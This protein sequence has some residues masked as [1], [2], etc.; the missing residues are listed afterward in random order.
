MSVAEYCAPMWMN[1]AH[2]KMVDTQNVALRIVFA[3][4][5][6]TPISWLYVMSNIAP[7]HLRRQ[8]A[9]IKECRK[10]DNNN[11]LPIFAT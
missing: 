2:V 4:V 8:E 5:D 10:I 3:A 11:K 6:S 1:S 9:S 7:S